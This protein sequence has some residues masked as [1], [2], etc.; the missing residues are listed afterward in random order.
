MNN[1]ATISKPVLPSLATEKLWKLL[2]RFA[3]PS[4]VSMLVI[5]LY[6][7]VDQLFIGHGVGY[8]GN[9]AT[10]V[11]FPVNL[12]TIAVSMMVGEGAAALYSIRLG[13]KKLDQAKAVIG[14]AFLLLAGI[15]IVF[16]VTCR[17]A[18]RPL[19]GF[20]GATEAVMPFAIDYATPIIY[21]I[22]FLVCA[23]GLNAMIRANGSPR[24]ALVAIASGAVLNTLLDPL[25]IF[26]FGMGV[27]GAGIA[28]ALSQC[29]GFLLSMRYFAFLNGFR[30][31]RRHIR[32]NN[33][34][35]GNILTCGLPAALSQLALTV[36]LVLMN[37]QLA[38]LG[39]DSV[40]GADIPLAMVGIAM[41]V[42]QILF[43]ILMGIAIGSQ[44][45]IG[46]NFGAGLYDRVKA[47]FRLCLT[48]AGGVGLAALAA[49]MLF[50]RSIIGMFGDGGER[51]TEFG[52]LCFRT[53]LPLTFLNAFTLL[54]GSF[55]QSMARVRQ[56]VAIQ[57]SRQLLF[58]APAIFLLPRLFG[59]EAILYAGP[60]TDFLAF[61][62]ALILVRREMR[63]LSNPHAEIAQRSSYA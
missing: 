25:F 6:N 42:N 52:V 5:S 53:F 48:V 9:A 22:P 21:G 40:Y 26:T 31:E 47:T 54:A 14:C 12:L 8:L 46:Y 27:R 13:E 20:L 55:F 7:V 10:N 49:F 17:L 15:G 51:Y 38:R 44:P 3:V 39:G 45:I 61:C 63:R 50:P 33:G 24:Y 60:V 1:D 43:A 32:W 57:L 58:M 29:V 2:L 18:L 35:A 34:L 23:P 11:V 36:V 56:A 4:V 37:K 41:K 30:L 59:F 28:T 19:L 62:L 16:A